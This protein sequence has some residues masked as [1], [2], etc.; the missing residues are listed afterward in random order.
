VPEVVFAQSEV[1]TV[2]RE[3]LDRLKREAQASP[4]RRARV[5]LHQSHDDAVQEMVIAFCR[6]SLV[7]PHRHVGRCESLHVIE[8]ELAVL[9]FDDAGHVERRIDLC[10]G[11]VAGGASIG[12][13]PTKPFMYR[14]SAPAWHTVAPCS[15]LVVVHE[16]TQGPFVVGDDGF[17]PWSPPVGPALEAFIAAAMAAA[18]PGPAARR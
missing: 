13:H 1:V 6:G 15:E 7:R 10:G 4:R 14:L 17:A 18:E 5:C 9:L 2:G 3:W 8:G 12:G 16:V 11:G